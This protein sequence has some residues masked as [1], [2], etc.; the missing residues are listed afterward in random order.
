AGERVG[1]R[2]AVEGVLPAQALLLEGSTLRFPTDVLGIDRTMAL[3][4]GVA[5][6]DEGN[7]LLVVH[8][9]AAEGL[10]DV[11]GGSER[12]RVAVGPL[13]IHVDQAHLHRADGPAELPVASVAIV[14]KPRV[15]SSPADVLFGSPVVLSPETEAERLEPHRL[16]GAVAGEDEQIG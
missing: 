3:A 4:E 15:L 6:G 1:A 12:I 7:G 10:P 5:P 8:R 16:H 11:L 14:S 2:T 13:R 9:H